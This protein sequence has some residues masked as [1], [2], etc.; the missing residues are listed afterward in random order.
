MRIFVF[1]LV[2]LATLILPIASAGYK[3]HT[4]QVSTNIDRSNMLADTVSLKLVPSSIT[5]AYDPTIN[6]FADKPVKLEIESDVY[7]FDSQLEIIGYQLFL[8]NNVSICYSSLWPETANKLDG[9]N[10]IA[11]VHIDNNVEPMQIGEA[12]TYSNTKFDSAN[13]VLAHD[14]MLKFKTLG[15]EEV[16][17]CNGSFA[18]GFR[19]DL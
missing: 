10:S 5:L 2:L 1:N 11:N 17:S 19:Y 12:I 18:V 15:D 7:S 13:S 16:R 9:Y 4:F 6:T 3:S 8:I 14:L